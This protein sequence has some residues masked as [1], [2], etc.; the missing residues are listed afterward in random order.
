M[1]WAVLIAA[2]LALAGCGSSTPKLNVDDSYVVA[3]GL[4]DLADA[5]LGGLEADRGAGRLIRVYRAHPDATFDVGLKR[6]HLR[7]MKQVM[8]NAA[9]DVESCHPDVAAKIDR[10]LR[11]E[12]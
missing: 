9:N 3:S 1:R 10:V 11:S 7:P 2:V 4:S 12:P 8:V 6:P 5:C